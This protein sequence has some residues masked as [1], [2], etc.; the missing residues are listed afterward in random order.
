MFFGERRSFK[1]DLPSVALAAAAVGLERNSARRARAVLADCL[2]STQEEFMIS[3]KPTQS[4]NVLFRSKVFVVC[5]LPDLVF[6][7]FT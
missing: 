3:P 5:A 1:R 6:L 7:G 2:V 4:G